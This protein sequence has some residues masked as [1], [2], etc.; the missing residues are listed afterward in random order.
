MASILVKEL[1][2]GLVS[3]LAQIVAEQFAMGNVLLLVKMHA[4]VVKQIVA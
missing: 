2:S 3:R 4:L 1:A